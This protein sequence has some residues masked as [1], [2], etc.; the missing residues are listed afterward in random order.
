MNG[1]TVPSGSI[2]GP[3]SAFTPVTPGASAAQAVAQ[4]AAAQGFMT[5]APAT[6]PTNQHVPPTQ[7]PTNRLLFPKHTAP[8]S[9]DSYTTQYFLGRAARL[10]RL[11]S[12]TTNCT[13]TPT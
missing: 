9:Q 8:F 1:S 5:P 2:G 7:A 11:E 3:S 4:V 6:I 12:H 13:S 10:P